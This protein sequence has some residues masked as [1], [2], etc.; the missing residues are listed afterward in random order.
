MMTQEDQNTE[1]KESWHDDYLKWICGFANAQGGRM[2]IGKTDKG[3][4]KGIDNAKWLLEAIPSKVK[5]ILGIMVDVNLCLQDGLAY[6]EIIVEA[7]PYP[8]SYKGQYHYRTG[9]TKQELK[10]T[11]LDHFLLGKQGRRWDG[12]PIPSVSVEE[13]AKSAMDY[14]RKN[15]ARAKR[16]EADDLDDSDAQLL[17]K[18]H[19]FD[20]KYLKRAAVLLFHSKPEK[21]ITGAYVKIGFFETD[22]DLLFQD[23][24]GGHLFDQVEKVMDLLLTKYIRATIGYEGLKRIE[25]YPYPEAALRE[26]LLNAIA[27]KDYSSGNPVQISVYPGKV[28]FWNESQLPDNWTVERL[29]SKHPSKPFN[30]DIAGV[31]F[32]AGLIEAWGRGTIKIFKE[33]KDRRLPDPVFKYDFSGFLLEFR[34]APTNRKAEV[35]NAKSIIL[36]QAII[37]ELMEAISKQASPADLS[38]GLLAGYQN[39]LERLEEKSLLILKNMY[40]QGPLRRFDI[41]DAVDLSNQTINVKRY[42]EPLV[43]LQMINSTIKDR[44]SSRLQRFVLTE[45]GERL[46][47]FLMEGL[48]KKRKRT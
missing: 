42:F 9:S 17:E 12:V 23:E 40:H 2:Y 29:A 7:Y 31:F 11:I 22:D 48:N 13:L 14:F 28:V 19:L 6:L 35:S 37:E 46:A 38:D 8:V 1:W 44:P 27:H 16:I 18:L 10:G 4:V 47:Q 33:C 5:D 39:A 32:R 15:A 41:L 36:S 26:A 21:Y 43:M 24:I 20:G 34:S 30:P 25:S 3:V 45:I